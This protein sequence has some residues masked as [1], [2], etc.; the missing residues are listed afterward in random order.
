MRRFLSEHFLKTE[1]GLSFHLIEA[2]GIQ[3]SAALAFFKS[4]LGMLAERPVADRYVFAVGSLDTAAC[5][6]MEDTGGF[7]VWPS[8]R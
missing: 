5:L 2:A 6:Q 3:S 8:M 4:S 7:I 1:R